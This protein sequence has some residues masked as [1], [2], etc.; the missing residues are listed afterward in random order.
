MSFP[1]PD[2]IHLEQATL[3][4]LDDFE[5]LT[6]LAG[7]YPAALIYDAC[8]FI[9][10]NVEFQPYTDSSF[11]TV[12]NDASINDGLLQLACGDGYDLFALSDDQSDAQ[13]CTIIDAGISD[14]GCVAFEVMSPDGNEI[15]WYRP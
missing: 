11:D 14:T 13:G 6:E 8:R 5:S 2:A 3:T 7:P 4:R 15:A 9:A 1:F 10:D 12:E